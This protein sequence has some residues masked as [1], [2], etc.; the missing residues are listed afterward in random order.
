MRKIL[1]VIGII[2]IANFPVVLMLTKARMF[3]PMLVIGGMFYLMYCILPG[4]ISGVVLRQMSIPMQILYG[5]CELISTAVICSV[6]SFGI[7]IRLFFFAPIEL[8]FLNIIFG[9]IALVL[10]IVQGMTRIIIFSKQVSLMKKIL[11]LLFW[12]VPIFNLILTYQ[13]CKKARLEC[14]IETHIR[15]L[16][17]TRAENQIC[18]TKYPV[19]MVH[20]IFFRDWQYFNYWG[21]IPAEL[22][23]N[24]AVVHYGNQQSS[25]S[26]VES[27]RE[28]SEQ[29]KQIVRDTGCEKVNIIAH[30]KG[31]LDSRYAISCLECAP[32]VAS[33]TTINT[34][35]M[36]CAWV[37]HVLVKIPKAVL[38]Y[39]EKRYNQAFKKLGDKQ[40]D[41]LGG[42]R[43]L[44]VESV[45]QFNQNVPDCEGILYQSTMS[46]MSKARSGKFPLNMG[47]RLIRKIQGSANDGLVPVEAA[48][49]GN[50]L[51][52]LR[53]S[54]IRGISHGDMIDLNRENIPG[55]DVREFYVSVIAGLK[56]RDL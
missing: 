52:V 28:L 24:G 20:G 18:R 48:R 39:A 17:E 45:A 47:Y 43:D 56:D 35:H 23:R 11:I 9:M 41:F 5:G 44:T 13:I 55:F 51:G 25:L 12:Y 33:L 2:W 53:A 19:L 36:G 7:N 21:R 1:T 49:W 3:I 54:A 14:E 31:G 32:F 37:D 27:A 4:R 42:L 10:L 46:Q 6:I 50:D 38:K 34:P 29:I 40:P 15:I 8:F 26:V 22:I 16:D 30:S